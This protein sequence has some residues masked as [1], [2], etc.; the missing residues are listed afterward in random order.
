MPVDRFS[1][2]PKKDGHARLTWLRIAAGFAMAGAL[3]LLAPWVWHAASAALGLLALAA[4]GLGAPYPS[5]AGQGEDR[6]F[7]R[8][9]CCSRVV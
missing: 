6:A 7:Q 3:A 8:R 4:L 2:L 5:A 9:T 1:H